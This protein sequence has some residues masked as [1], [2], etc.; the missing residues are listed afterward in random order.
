MNSARKEHANSAH[1]SDIVAI[2]YIDEV[3]LMI[4]I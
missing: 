4:D 1:I 3:G 2:T